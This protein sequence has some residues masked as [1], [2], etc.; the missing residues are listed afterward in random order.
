MYASSPAWGD[1]A[2]SNPSEMVA[3][4]TEC[5]DGEWRSVLD[6]FLGMRKVMATLWWSR[7]LEN[8]SMGNVALDGIWQH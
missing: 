4:E 8:W 7:R 1:G 6:K 5:C 2:S 3:T